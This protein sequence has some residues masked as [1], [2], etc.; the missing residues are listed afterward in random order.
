[1]LRRIQA[2]I[3]AGD[4][5]AGGGLSARELEVLSF[6]AEGMPDDEI[7]Q[8]LELGT[9]KVSTYVASIL[10]KLQLEQ[11]VADASLARRR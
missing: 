8:A 1:L 2:S 4:D 6:L 11:R 10:G 5:L 3:H 7:A 9:A